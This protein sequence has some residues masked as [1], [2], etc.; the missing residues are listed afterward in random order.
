MNA[1][2]TTVWASGKTIIGIGPFGGFRILRGKQC[3]VILGWV[4][5]TRFPVPLKDILNSRNVLGVLEDRANL[6]S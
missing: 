3:A 1:K 4:A 6:T 2:Y 5:I